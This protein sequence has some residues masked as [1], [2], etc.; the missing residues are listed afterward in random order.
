MFNYE[1]WNLI[2]WIEPQAEFSINFDED[3]NRLSDKDL[4]RRKELM[5]IN[6][7]KN[8]IKVGDPSFVYDKQVTSFLMISLQQW[9]GQ[10]TANSSKMISFQLKYISLDSWLLPNPKT[11]PPCKDKLI[12][13]L[14]T[15]SRSLLTL[16]NHQLFIVGM[17]S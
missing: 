2:C 5:E 7:Q 11:I 14:N 16:V 15:H 1:K 13:I 9:A 17:K 12:Q 6:F 4:R 3:M 10:I 8:Q